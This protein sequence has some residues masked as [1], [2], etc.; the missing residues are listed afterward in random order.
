L[1]FFPL[2]FLD[3]IRR[4]A[5]LRGTFSIHRRPLTSNSIQPQPQQQIREKSPNMNRNSLIRLTTSAVIPSP[6]L[7]K[8]DK[9]IV[10]HASRIRRISQSKDYLLKSSEIDTT[11]RINSPSRINNNKRNSINKPLKSLSLVSYYHISRI[12][13]YF[14]L[15]PDESDEYQWRESSN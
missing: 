14:F 13:V 7:N 3:T 11:F 4:R 15:F 6:S 10:R 12:F 9:D 1:L 2:L 5:G 8:I